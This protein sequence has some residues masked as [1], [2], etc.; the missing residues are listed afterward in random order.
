MR[1]AFF[2]QPDSEGSWSMV[3][4]GRERGIK[5]NSLGSLTL[6]VSGEVTGGTAHE[7]GVDRKQPAGGAI[8]ISD[9]GSLSGFID[10]YLP[11][12]DSRE[13]YTI[14][15]GLMAPEKDIMVFGGKFPTERKGIV[16][17]TSRK[18]AFAQPDLAGTWVV[19]HDRAYSL[20]LDKEGI[21][22]ECA[23][24]PGGQAGRK[25][26]EGKFSLDPSGAVSASMFF[27]GREKA[28]ITVSGQLNSGKNF[29]ALA[30][31]DS[32]HFEG[33]TLPLIKREGGLSSGDTEGMW[34]LWMTGSHGTFIGTLGIDK[35]GN[36]REGAWVR[37][38]FI[39]NETGALE[40]GAFSLTSDGEISGSFK[41][42]SGDTYEILGGQMGP[43]KDVVGALYLDRSRIQGMM[44]LMRIP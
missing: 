39:A 8:L 36:V 40:S 41:T 2:A 38:G 15:G 13:K 23:L 32:T 10:T 44:L 12:S 16:I 33:I 4:F 34:R 14:E 6:N 18:G 20:L 19:L 24:G 35:E 28:V 22:T 27:S 5:F 17:L 26:C 11:D 43:K 31:S 21:I 25:L 1:K 7:F 30:G 42:S 37:I 3:G 29:M 9:Q